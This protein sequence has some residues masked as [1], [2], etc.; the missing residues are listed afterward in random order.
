MQKLVFLI[1]IFALSIECRFQE[2][3]IAAASQKKEPVIIPET[4][5][6]DAYTLHKIN[7]IIQS[8][9][10]DELLSQSKKISLISE[11][12]LGTPYQSNTLDGSDIKPEK[13]IINFKGLDCFTYLDYVVA[14]HISHSQNDFLKNIIKTRYIDANI[15]FYN[16]KHFFTDWANREYKIAED[17]TTQLS[18]HTV[19]CVKSLN[20]KTKTQKYLPGIPVVSRSINYIPS[21]AINTT[22]ISKLKSGDLIGIYTPLPGLDVT[23]VGF[24]LTTEKG[25]VFRHAS[26]SKDNQL[27]VDSPLMPYLLKTPGII[28]L[29]LKSP[30]S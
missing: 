3:I 5:N 28:I 8:I 10:N 19:K 18:P 21:S 24:F 25:P 26:S 15:S 4:T 17:I 23:H 27:V 7:T 12:F 13:L 9:S 14:L 2:P 20:Q 16:R 11:K 29:R 6:I 30:S 22:L 1:I